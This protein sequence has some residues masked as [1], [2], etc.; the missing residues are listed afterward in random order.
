M[1]PGSS[2][3]RSDYCWLESNRGDSEFIASRS[4]P[5][6]LRHVESY[7][8]HHWNIAMAAISKR[9]KWVGEHRRRYYK[10]V[11]IL[12]GDGAVVFPRDDFE[13]VQSGGTLVFER[14]QRGNYAYAKHQY[15]SGQRVYLLRTKCYTQRIGIAEHLQL[16][17]T[18]RVYSR[19]PKHHR[20]TNSY[21]HVYL[22]NF[23]G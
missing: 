7:L 17:G 3:Y 23:A 9:S 22:A 5:G 14:N 20:I 12:P 15:Y 19:Y 21:Y 8:V 2:G 16:V 4:L 10:S 1:L 6:K 18:E 13:S 11:C